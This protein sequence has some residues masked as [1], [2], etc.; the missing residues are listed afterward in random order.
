MLLRITHALVQRPTCLLHVSADHE[1]EAIVHI[2]PAP[3]E[4]CWIILLC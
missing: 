1:T 4:E 3:A 2:G